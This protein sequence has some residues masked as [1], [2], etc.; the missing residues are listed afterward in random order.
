MNSRRPPLATIGSPQTAHAGLWYD[1]YLK[2]QPTRG[3]ALTPYQELV[4]SCQYLSRSLTPAYKQFLQRWR[5]TLKASNVSLYEAKSRGRQVIGL[6]SAGVIENAITLHHTYG[7]PYL[8]ES[9]LKGLA[10]HYAANYVD[11]ETWG[12]VDRYKCIDGSA[13]RSLHESTYMNYVDNTV[14]HAVKGLV[15]FN[16]LSLQ[17]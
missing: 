12:K 8:P 4:Q 3:E 1:K 17:K 10:A 13:V 2:Q 6:G 15:E 16:N 11:E 7:V 5:R 14:P 9:A